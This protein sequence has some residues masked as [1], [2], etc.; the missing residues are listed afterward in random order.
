MLAR[1]I[2]GGVL[3]WSLLG[4]GALALAEPAE[5]KLFQGKTAQGFKIKLLG[6]EKAFKIHV[7]DAELKCSDGDWLLLE[8]GGFLWTRV[9]P[10]GSFKDAQF[11]RTDSVYF[12]GRMTERRI[13]GRLRVTDKLKGGVRCRSRWI[14]FNATPR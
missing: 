10:N 3:A 14:R 11:G 8:E 2:T 1:F 4:A 5:A 13:R 9:S 7:F 6:K 12:R